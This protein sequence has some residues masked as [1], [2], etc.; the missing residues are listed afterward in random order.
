[1]ILNSND[2]KIICKYTNGKD[3]DLDQLPNGFNKETQTN[4]ILQKEYLV[5]GILKFEQH[6]YFLVDEDSIPFWFP[7][8]LF[9]VSDS[10]LKSNWHFKVSNESESPL[11]EFT[12]GYFE[13]C[14][15]E[16]HNDRLMERNSEDLQ[17][18]FRQK[19]AIEETC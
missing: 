14:F 11:I 17:I 4:L 12:L 16:G 5:M 18:Y 9:E 15:L 8:I 2:M 6:I 19:R 1:M 10:R 13:L 3:F 7:S